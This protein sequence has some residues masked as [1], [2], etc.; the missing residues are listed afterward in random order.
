M[1]RENLP[2]KGLFDENKS[3]Q[4]GG[5]DFPTQFDTLSSSLGLPDGAARR[6]FP[7]EQMLVLIE[8]EQP[9]PLD[10]AAIVGHGYVMSYFSAAGSIGK[11]E[12]H[13]DP[14]LHFD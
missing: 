4:L 12:I 7:F 3:E 1:R 5:D 14:L 6:Y 11:A 9:Q 10:V 13:E 2:I 8:R